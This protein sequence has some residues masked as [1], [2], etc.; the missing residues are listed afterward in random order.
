MVTTRVNRSLLVKIDLMED[1]IISV[2]KEQFSSSSVTTSSSSM[3]DPATSKNT[4][5]VKVKKTY[6]EE[7]DILKHSIKHWSVKK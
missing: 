5:K 4:N 1:E 6:N 3:R 2:N 7:L